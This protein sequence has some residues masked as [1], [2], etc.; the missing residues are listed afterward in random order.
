MRWGLILW[1]TD[2]L[3]LHSVAE[4]CVEQCAVTAHCWGFAAKLEWGFCDCFCLVLEDERNRTADACGTALI[5]ATVFAWC[6]WNNKELVYNTKFCKHYTNI[7]RGCYG[8][9]NS[10][11]VKNW[12]KFT[13]HE[14]CFFS[15]ISLNSSLST[16]VLPVT[17]G[18][19]VEAP[20]L[21]C[22]VG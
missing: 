14:P 19:R 10:W 20:H 13:H 4:H 6:T 1:R 7:V 3:Q 2:W 21:Y 15:I 17:V 11:C 12:K 16:L 18:Y 9:I 22:W 8:K 5:L